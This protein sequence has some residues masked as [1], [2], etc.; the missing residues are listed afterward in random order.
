MSF[1]NT[2]LPLAIILLII[3]SGCKLPFALLKYTNDKLKEQ[4]GVL[5]GLGKVGAFLDAEKS[6][7]NIMATVDVDGDKLDPND[8]AQITKVA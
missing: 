3:M 4:G 1:K 8:I 7:Y 5:G 6:E 2:L